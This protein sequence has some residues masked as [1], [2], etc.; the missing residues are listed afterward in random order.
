MLNVKGKSN[1]T[2]T[3]SKCEFATICTLFFI[4]ILFCNIFKITNLFS[5]FFICKKV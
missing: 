4:S 1:L 3:R 2:A 5:D